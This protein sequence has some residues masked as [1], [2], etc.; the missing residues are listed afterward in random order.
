VRGYN[1]NVTPASEPSCISA[2]SASGISGP[3][4]E[5]DVK[6]YVA[7][8]TPPSIDSTQF[9][10][11]ICGVSGDAACASSGPTVCTS[12]LLNGDGTVAQTAESNYPGCTVSVQVAYA[13]PF[14]FPL[15]PKITTITAPCTTAGLCI[16]SESQMIIVH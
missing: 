3:T 14:I 11:S 16:S 12:N 6:A 15:L 2:N 4:T 9:K 1:C 13:Y 7:S 5:A 10:Y 8:I